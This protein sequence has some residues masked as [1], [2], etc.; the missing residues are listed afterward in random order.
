M[1]QIHTQLANKQARRTRRVKIKKLSRKSKYC[2]SREVLFDMNWRKKDNLVKNKLQIGEN[3]N[4]VN[5]SKCQLWKLC[6]WKLT[7]WRLYAKYAVFSISSLHNI[8]CSGVDWSGIFTKL[9]PELGS[10]ELE[11]K[12]VIYWL[13]LEVILEALFISLLISLAEALSWY[14]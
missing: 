1:S 5:L 9:F 8:E 4:V 12:T 7:E 6:V 2:T 10:D 3:Y 13:G 14:L 11:S